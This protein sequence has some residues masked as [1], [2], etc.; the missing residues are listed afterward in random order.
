MGVPVGT[1]GFLSSLP[2]SRAEKLPHSRLP[3]QAGSVTHWGTAASHLQTHQGSSTWICPLCHPPSA[4]TLLI[5][6]RLPAAEYFSGM[7]L[8]G[9][10]HSQWLSQHLFG[11]GG[12]TSS[13]LW[14]PSGQIQPN[15]EIWH[16]SLSLLGLFV[17]E[18]LSLSKSQCSPLVATGWILKLLIA[19]Q[20]RVKFIYKL[21]QSI[22]RGSSVLCCCCFLRELHIW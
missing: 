19:Q 4:D 11:P 20:L 16:Y 2:S 13:R 21:N 14:S 18:V 22:I 8:E 7:H 17:E 15:T 5:F 12:R 1:T 9:W 3:P 10:T 6:L